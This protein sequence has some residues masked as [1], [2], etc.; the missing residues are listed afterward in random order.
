VVARRAQT[1]L[2]V[3]KLV[4]GSCRHDHDYLPWKL[5]KRLAFSVKWLLAPCNVEKSERGTELEHYDQRWAAGSRTRDQHEP[6]FPHWRK[7]NSVCCT[8]SLSPAG[9]CWFMLVY[10]ACISF[11]SIWLALCLVQHND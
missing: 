4:L 1:Y 10:V 9:E 3:S 5:I 7:R 11:R 2:E 6:T 8:I